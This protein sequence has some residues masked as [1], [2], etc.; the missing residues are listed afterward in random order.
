[1]LATSGPTEGSA[2]AGGI[3]VKPG[4]LFVSLDCVGGA[5]LT[6]KLPPV[7]ELA[8]PCAADKVTSTFNEVVLKNA[9]VISLRVEAPAEV[10]WAFKVQQ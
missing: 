2:P 4:S 9:R 5:T 1:M 3:D 10:T 7:T 6:L 8:I